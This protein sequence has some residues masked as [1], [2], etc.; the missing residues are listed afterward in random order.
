MT[1]LTYNGSGE[2]MH[3]GTRCRTCD[4]SGVEPYD[5]DD[6]EAYDRAANAAMDRALDEALD[7][8]DGL[9]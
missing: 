3:E 5:E 9:R 2:G 7:Y 6:E 1:T 4:G 8:A